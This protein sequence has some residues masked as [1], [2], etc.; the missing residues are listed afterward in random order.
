MHI[1]NLKRDLRYLCCG[2]VLFILLLEDYQMIRLQLVEPSLAQV[3]VV[4]FVISPS[5]F[6]FDREVA[7]RPNHYLDTNRVNCVCGC[8]VGVYDTK[9]NNRSVNRPDKFVFELPRLYLFCSFM[10]IS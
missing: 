9:P 10:L 4:E 1:L 7:D 8:R 2:G 3:Q 5:L 6:V